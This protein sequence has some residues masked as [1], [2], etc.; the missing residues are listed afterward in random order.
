MEVVFVFLAPLLWI[1]LLYYQL[2]TGT[3]LGRSFQVWA[4][5]EE[6][7][8]LFWALIAFQV[9]GG[10]VSWFVILYVLRQGH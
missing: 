9:V 4:T 3:A 5:R 10:A 8:E 2:E 7:P 6:S 1:A